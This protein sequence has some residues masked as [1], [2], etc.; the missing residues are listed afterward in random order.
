MRLPLFQASLTFTSVEHCT[1][2]PDQVENLLRCVIYLLCQPRPTHTVYQSSKRSRPGSNTAKNLRRDYHP[3]TRYNRLRQIPASDQAYL[4]L[5][6][7]TIPS[8]TSIGFRIPL[9]L[10]SE[11]AVFVHPWSISRQRSS[12]IRT[13]LRSFRRGIP[14]HT[15]RSPDPTI[16]NYDAIRLTS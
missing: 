6:R 13:L 11:D 2:A 10:R 7:P 15:F 14:G 8:P 4:R 3:A 16:R 9:H 5:I 1:P 12:N